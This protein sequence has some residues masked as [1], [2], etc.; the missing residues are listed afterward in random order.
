MSWVYTTVAVYGF[1]DTWSSHEGD[2]MIGS[3]TQ[4]SWVKITGDREQVP[5]NLTDEWVRVPQYFTR[6]LPL[7][8]SPR[9]LTFVVLFMVTIEWCI[10]NVLLGL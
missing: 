4:I 5:Q 6:V 10:K 9:C 3:R 1:T 2:A 7:G 8:N